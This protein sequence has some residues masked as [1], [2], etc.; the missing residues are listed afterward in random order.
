[1]THNSI[2][3]IKIVITNHSRSNRLQIIFEYTRTCILFIIGRVQ[4]VSVFVAFYFRM[5]QSHHMV[6]EFIV[7]VGFWRVPRAKL[8]RCCSLSSS[9]LLMML[10]L[11]V[12]LSVWRYTSFALYL[13][14]QRCNLH[15]RLINALVRTFRRFKMRVRC[16]SLSKAH[17]SICRIV[18]T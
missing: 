10:L 6:M 9:P 1:M 18:S 3:P 14:R 17:S 12:S 15:P 2:L 16:R 11:N 8:L 5:K 4:R 7:S 13:T